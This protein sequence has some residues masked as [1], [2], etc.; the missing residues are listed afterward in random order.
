[1]PPPPKNCGWLCSKSIGTV[2]FWEFKTS[3]SSSSN[4]NINI[5]KI[6]DNNNNTFE[7]APY[8]AV[9][10]EALAERVS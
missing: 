6:K 10:S 8:N 5:N 4:I 9:A 3:H 1:L 2:R 7:K